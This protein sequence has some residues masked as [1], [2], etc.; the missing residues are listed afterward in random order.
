MP[1]RSCVKV[2][3]AIRGIQLLQEKRLVGT[4]RREVGNRICAL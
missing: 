2:D 1:F 3:M 4:K